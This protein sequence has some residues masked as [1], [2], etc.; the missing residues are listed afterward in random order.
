MSDV[1]HRPNCTSALL[2]RPHNNQH[3]CLFGPGPGQGLC[4]IY[5]CKH[6]VRQNHHEHVSVGEAAMH[7][8]EPTTRLG[9]I[10]RPRLE[11]LRG[12][13]FANN[14]MTFPDFN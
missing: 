11:K 7:L 4:A 2:P 8:L 12:N 14:S 5:V 10:D 13:R 3:F 1:P 6:S 9:V